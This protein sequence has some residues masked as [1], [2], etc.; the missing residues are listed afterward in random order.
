[1]FFV[2]FSPT[3][4]SF[5][6]YSVCEQ[7]TEIFDSFSNFVYFVYPFKPQIIFH[8]YV[9]SQQYFTQVAVALYCLS[10]SSGISLL[11]Y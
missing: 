8:A 3:K 1:M 4:V 7:Q 2:F 6:F 10:F 9:V 5:Q 11:K